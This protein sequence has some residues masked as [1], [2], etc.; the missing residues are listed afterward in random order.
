LAWTSN[1]GMSN[2]LAVALVATATAIA[3]TPSVA[4]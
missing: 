1:M 2:R 4:L 3:I